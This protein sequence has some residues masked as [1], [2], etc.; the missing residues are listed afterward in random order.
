MHKAI[1]GFVLGLGV[2]AL[3]LLSPFHTESSTTAAHAQA[4]QPVRPE[5]AGAERV[6]PQRASNN[7]IVAQANDLAE[8]FPDDLG[9]PTVLSPSAAAPL[10]YV[11]DRRVI[12]TLMTW[13]GNRNQP[14][15]RLDKWE[16]DGNDQ[17]AIEWLRNYIEPFAEVGIRR[18]C[19]QLP[20]GSARGRMG[21]SHFLTMGNERLERLAR[22]FDELEIKYPGIEFGA[23]VGWGIDY[24]PWNKALEGDPLPDFNNYHHR[25]AMRRQLEPLRVFGFDFLGLDAFSRGRNTGQ[26]AMWARWIEDELGLRIIGEAYPMAREGNNRRNPLELMEEEV[27]MYPAAGVANFINR[28]EVPGSFEQ[29]RYVIFSGHYKPMLERNDVRRPMVDEWVRRGFVPWIYTGSASQALVELAAYA[30]FALQREAR[31]RDAR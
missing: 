30:E 11:P 1:A 15:G 21:Y 22:L 26:N 12:V 18:F 16:A 29:S 6:R 14:D 5:R 10:G 8:R 24:E 3:G 20:A 19:L 7:R 27:A 4:A 2:A 31:Q 9:K 17:Q 13:N 28:H 25:Q 23:Y